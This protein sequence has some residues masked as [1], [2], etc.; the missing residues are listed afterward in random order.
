[1]ELEKFKDVDIVI[2][3]VNSSFNFNPFVSQNDNDGR[4]LTVQ[5][6]ENGA[7]GE[8]PGL[9]LNLRWSNQTSGLT[10]LSAFQLI[11]KEKSLFQ[12][13]YPKNMLNPGKVI[14]SIQIIQ[15]G[16]VAHSKQFE[17][18]VQQLAGEAKG[19]IGKAE[20]SALVEVLADSNKFRTDI[21]KLDGDKAN[22]KD[23]DEM[24]R[25][26]GSG[27]PKGKFNTF[28]E[29]KLKYPNGAEGIY[30]VT[31]NGHWYYWDTSAKSW[32]D[33][34]V[35]QATELEVESVKTENFGDT[36]RGKN[37][38]NKA[39]VE[40]GYI[41]RYTGLITYDEF[42]VSSYF[43]VVPDNTTFVCSP[44]I[45]TQAIN[46]GIYNQSREIIN[47]AQILPQ[48]TDQTFSTGPNE[49]LIRV[50]FPKTII[51]QFQLE[52]G[53]APTA[54][55][56]YYHYFKELTPAPSESEKVL[57]IEQV[58]TEN[59]GETVKGKNLFNKNSVEVGYIDRDTGEVVFNEHNVTST[60]IVVPENA[61]LVFSPDVGSNINVAKYNSKRGFMS[62]TQIT[63][64]S[65]NR[66]ISTES[67]E[68][69][70]RFSVG[71]ED[72]DLIQLELGQY[73]TSY[74]EYYNYLP[75]ITPTPAPVV[76]D[77]TKVHVL[78]NSVGKQELK[79]LCTLGDEKRFFSY[80][81][82]YEN[83]PYTDGGL[84]Q[85]AELWRLI[86]GDI[87]TLDPTDQRVTSTEKI[88]NDGAW[89]CAIQLEG[90]SDFHGTYHGY[91]MMDSIDLYLNNVKA[92]L[93][94]K[95]YEVVD[96]VRV[97]FKSDLIKQGSRDEVI[98]NVIRSYEWTR[99]GLVLNQ[100]IK[101]LQDFSKVEKGYLAM[102]PILRLADYSDPNSKM[103][104]DRAFSD[105]DYK[106]YDVS[107]TAPSEIKNEVEK[108]KTAVVYGESSGYSAEVTMDYMNDTVKNTFHVD[109]ALYYNKL[110]FS[111][112][113]GL[114]VQNGDVWQ[115]KTSY[116][117][118]AK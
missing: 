40:S 17:I 67:G 9:S 83:K 54:F 57:T 86:G 71:K 104:T 111:Y 21:D 5:I 31:Q 75:D 29:L 85:N 26:V 105:Y 108:V 90:L 16:Q 98:A 6:T 95:I 118:K 99:D 63:S 58:R 15:N 35:Y 30:L 114:P 97:V 33:G 84:Y 46:I 76:P 24:I 4:T 43:I 64:T 87:V 107:T 94:S 91:E 77:F 70:L 34:G 7:I 106:E 49:R 60:Y 56:E 74:E 27:A 10:D 101:W 51:E 37:L 11:N 110:Y 96:K 19:I 39:S 44:K 92:D 69:L 100:K 36:V 52:V 112:N 2:N 47:S 48:S 13:K 12:I 18:T 115:S 68:Q 79:I 1:M 82:Q 109:N 55:E 22:K 59:I 73:P 93:N 102:L 62:S 53:T 65:S 28:D 117:F 20:Y 25:T 66:I 88:V 116:A 38:F 32:M 42:N 72:K 3:H 78:K 61:K 103:I 23:V 80:N 8:V 89:E 41:D 50:S 81:L 113:T 14:A 45:S